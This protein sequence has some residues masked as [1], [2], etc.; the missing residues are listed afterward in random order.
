MYYID[1]LEYEYVT[2]EHRIKQY[3]Y[4]IKKSSDD[5]VLN[6]STEPIIEDEE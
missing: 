6:K 1:G 4:L 3:I 2:E 5:S